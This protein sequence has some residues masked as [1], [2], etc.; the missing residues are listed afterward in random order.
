MKILVVGGSG[1]VATWTIPYMRA[2]HEFRVLDVRPPRVDG[3][4]YVEGSMTD[5]KALERA[6]DG[7]DSFVNMV[8]KSPTS[9]SVAD[10]DRRPTVYRH[11]F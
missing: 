1:N 10:I 2:H 5:P 11:F 3:V 8:M 4:E 6:L 9:L 7:V